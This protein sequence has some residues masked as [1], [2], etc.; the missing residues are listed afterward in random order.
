MQILK[1]TRTHGK[2]AVIPEET[3]PDLSASTGGSPAEVAEHATVGTKTP[4]AVV[5]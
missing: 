3:G 5:L 2:K 4:A 1:C